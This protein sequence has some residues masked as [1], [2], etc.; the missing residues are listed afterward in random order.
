MDEKVKATFDADIL[1]HTLLAQE[2]A[3][4]NEATSIF[5]NSRQRTTQ[6]AQTI[7]APKVHECM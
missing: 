2:G 5:W 4:S 1:F 3:I 6:T 7:M